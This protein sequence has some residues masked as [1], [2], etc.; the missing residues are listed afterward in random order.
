[1][2]SV[3]AATPGPA[4]DAP[5]R[6]GFDLTALGAL[7][8]LALRQHLRGRRLL[9][10]ALLFLLP[11]VLAVVV[12]LSPYAPPADDVAFALVFNL[13]P[14]ALVPLT[15]L[16]FAAGIIQD[17][18]EGQTLTYLLLRPLPRWALYLTKLAAT[19]LVTA[20]LTGAF[21]VL[22]FAV[23]Y[24]NTADLWGS[25]LSGRALK[26]AALMALA[27]AAY[28]SLFAFLGQVTRWALLV[29]LAYIVGFEGLLANFAFVGRRLTV[30]YYFRVLSVRW[31]DLPAADV[32]SLDL[33]TAAS[34][35][36]CVLTLLGA[37][38]AFA[39]LGAA[40]MVGQEFRMKTPEGS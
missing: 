17:E 5:L 30:M 19:V 6:R 29:G 4:A 9:L 10:L 36:T 3:L 37:S 11:S 22:T 15:A 25:V 20:V 16:L 28:C 31:L 18:V 13:I 1:M 39:L 40:L 32:W 7:F 38:A 2:K 33:A 34:A 12:R 23:I 8:V 24:W 14:H 21:T 27:Q 26:A 35:R